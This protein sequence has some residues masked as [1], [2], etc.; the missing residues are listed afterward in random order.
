M[1]YLLYSV[2]STLLYYILSSW[3]LQVKKTKKFIVVGLISAL[4]SLIIYLK[5]NFG[6]FFTLE[7]LIDI[8]LNFCFIALWTIRVIFLDSRNKNINW[9]LKYIPILFFLYFF[10]QVFM[11]L[12]FASYDYLSFVIARW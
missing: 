2:V 4:L 8:F 3:V 12:V 5:F 11:A 1:F 6:K 9:I 7:S 10:I